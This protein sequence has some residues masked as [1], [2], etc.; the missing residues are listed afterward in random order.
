MTRTATVVASSHYV[1]FA[2]ATSVTALLPVIFGFQLFA[3]HLGQ[4]SRDI[5]SAGECRGDKCASSPR[6]REVVADLESR[7]MNC[8]I[9]PALTD[10]V[11]FEWRDRHVRVVDFGA[12]LRASRSGEGWARQY[13]LP[14]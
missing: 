10:N 7:G 9:K 13:C 5:V 1:R 2:V 11:V 4:T 14:A 3:S 6:V 8:R 12:A